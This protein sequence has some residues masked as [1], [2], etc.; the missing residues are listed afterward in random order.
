MKKPI[1]FI[2]TDAQSL[3][4]RSF[5][6]E[7]TALVDECD[8]TY[9][10]RNLKITTWKQRKASSLMNEPLFADLD[11]SETQQKWAEVGSN[12]I[13]STFCHY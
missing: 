8:P 7:F 12:I 2:F 4:I 3:R 6:P 1:R 10:G 11:T 5:F 9:A 13:R